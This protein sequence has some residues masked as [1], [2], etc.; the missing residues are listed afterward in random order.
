[1]L[2]LQRCGAPHCPAI[3]AEPYCAEH[4]GTV[5]VEHRS[6][7]SGKRRPRA[8]VASGGEG[9]D[10]RWMKLRARK[11]RRDPTCEWPDCE[12]DAEH[13]HHI[14][15]LGCRGPRGYDMGNLTSLCA[16]HH[17][18][19][20]AQQRWAGEPVQLPRRHRALVLRR[21]DPE[22]AQTGECEGV[23]SGSVTFG[24]LAFEPRWRPF[25]GSKP[26]RR[27]AAGTRR[28][29]ARFLACR[30]GR[31]SL[32]HRGPRAPE[33]PAA[34]ASGCRPAHRRHAR[35]SMRRGWSPKVGAAQRR[36]TG[37]RHFT[38]EAAQ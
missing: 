19:I 18:L 20:S 17:N 9:Y 3:Q 35:A 4:I 37:V 22:L 7:T 5:T 30:P 10:R 6:E 34:D 21:S 31:C 14:D 25:L 33:G 32:V 29:S 15:G 36:S 1:M 12:R 13:V 11:L 38:R 28:P 23:R 27:P 16:A 26:A 24:W 8:S 2:L